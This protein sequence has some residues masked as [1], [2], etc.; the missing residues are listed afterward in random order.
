MTP[1][2][3]TAASLLAAMFLAAEA[4]AGV[5]DYGADRGVLSFEDSAFPAVPGRHSSLSLSPLH[6][7]LGSHSLEWKWRREEATLSIPGEIPYLKSNPDPRETSVSTF[8]FWVYADEALPGRLRFSFRKGGRECCHFE[9]GLGFTGWRGAWVAFDRDMEGQPEEGM[10]EIVITAPSGVRKGRLWFDGII[11]SAFEDARYHTADRQA[12][13]I[14]AGTDIHWLVLNRS[15]NLRLDIL[16]TPLTSPQEEDMRLVEERFISLVTPG[17]TVPTDSLRR[18][19]D[20]YGIRLNRDG[21]ICGKPVF[22]TRYGETY[23]NLGIRDAS[24]S[25]R[26]NGQLLRDYNDNLLNLAAAYRSLDEGPDKAELGRMYVMMT[27]HLL[28]QGF[29]AESAQGTLHHLGYS[30]RN[31][32]TAPMLMKDVLREAGLL[33]EVQAA[34]EWFSGVGEVKTAPAE[35]G[36]DIDAFNTSLMGRMASIL[37]LEPSSYKYAYLKAI[38]RW[39]DNGFRYVDGTRPCFKPDGSI[40]HHRRAYPAYA[41]G[42]LDGAVNSVWML[43]G[44]SLAVSQESHQILKDALL[45]MRFR[46]NLRSFPLAMSGR[47]PDG[48]GAL[49]PR[50]FA[51]L[52]D[53]GSP[54]GKSLTGTD[55]ASAYLRLTADSRKNEAVWRNRFIGAGISPE[56]TP[57]GSRSYGYD[58]SLSHRSGEALVTVAGHSRYLWSAEIYRGANHYGRYLTHGSMQILCGGKPVISSFGSGFQ[59]DGWDWCHIPGTTAAELPMPQ[60]KADVLNVDEFSGYEEMLLSDEWFAGGVTHRGLYGAFAMKL[61]EHDKYNG[62]LRARKSFFAFGDRVVALGSDLENVLEGSQL[63][64]TLFQNSI[65]D[66]SY[67]EVDGVRTDAQEY[68]AELNEPLA[69]LKDRLGNSYFVSNARVKVF[70]GLQH[71]LHE[72]TDAPTEGRFEKAYICHGGI[73]GKNTAPD[74]GYVKDDY[75]YMVGILAPDDKVREW[76]AS[77]PYKVVRKDRAAHIVRDPESGVTG[78]AVF[79]GGAVDSLIAESTPAVIMYSFDG[80]TLRLSVCN[81]DLALYRGEPDEVY[82]PDG[83]RL[84][85]S[86]Y[87]REWIDAHCLPTEVRIRLKGLW[88]VSGSGCSV[89]EHLQENGCT[90]LVFSTAEARTEEITLNRTAL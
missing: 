62:S 68:F 83:K 31:F 14:N 79:E 6:F 34:M 53:A 54:D 74:D 90:D 73:V 30:M 84:E 82:G 2:F 87:G 12:P 46:C 32:Y 58:C 50:H 45:Q 7:K 71:S 81:P 18:M 67:T 16:Q 51:L 5:V 76:K 57:Q 24:A 59:V 17:K 52:A 29:A 66:T 61:H 78:C 40:F 36:M 47:H 49:L 48:R 42:G 63:H 39:I 38:S 25:F 35:P 64:T 86:V 37:I 21:T 85:R 27:R 60:M 80:D 55:L 3:K 41:V 23:I 19:Y 10:D 65:S 20:S 88:E 26:K 75:E 72:E 1:H 28:D 8:V 9:Y 4:A 44:T 89:V 11:I 33:D 13:F 69:V 56:A 15:W 43:R 77:L 70:R 22:F